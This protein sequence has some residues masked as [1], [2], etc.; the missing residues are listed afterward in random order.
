MPPRNE[1]A[2]LVRTGGAM[3]AFCRERCSPLRLARLAIEGSETA[4]SNHWE[5]ASPAASTATCPTGNNEHKDALGCGDVLDSD[6]G[7]SDGEASVVGTKQS[8][9]L[10]MSN[11][12]LLVVYD[13]RPQART[14]GP[15][16]LRS[17]PYAISVVSDALSLIRPCLPKSNKADSLAAPL[18]AIP[19]SWILDCAAEYAILPLSTF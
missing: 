14:K 13:S 9:L 1:L 11:S 5:L 2:H 15:T 4:Q 17:T 8:E 19:A 12:P 7:E 6:D 16:D 18:R 10:C 3:V